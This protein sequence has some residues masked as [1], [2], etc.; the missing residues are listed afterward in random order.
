MVLREIQLEE[1]R[2]YLA[3][4]PK[5]WEVPLASTNMFWLSMKSTYFR[6][7]AQAIA[8]LLDNSIQAGA[9]KVSIDLIPAK[10]GKLVDKIIISDDGCGMEPRMMSEALSYGGTQRHNNRTGTGRFGMGMPNSTFTQADKVTIIS[11]TKDGKIH[12]LVFDGKL[13]EEGKYTSENG[14]LM[15]PEANPGTLPKD[16]EDIVTKSGNK[17]E[18]GTILILEGLS[19]MKIQR[20]AAL[21]EHLRQ[22]L[23]TIFN[24]QLAVPTGNKNDL[25]GK[26]SLFIEGKSVIPADPLFLT[27]GAQ[28]FDDDSSR[29]QPFQS[30]KIAIEQG[31][32]KGILRCEFALVEPTFWL[33][34]KK[35]SPV[36]SKNR[37]G[38]RF[39]IAKQYEGINIYRHDRLIDTVSNIP[40]YVWSNAPKGIKTKWLNN[41]RT[42]RVALYFE[43]VLDE[44][45]GV[46]VTKQQ[47]M[48]NEFIWN[49]LKENGF[50][51]TI[52]AM[53]SADAQARRSA[54]I[55]DDASEDGRRPSEVVMDNILKLNASD[56]SAAVKSF[57]NDEGEKCIRE[58]AEKN[59]EKLNLELTEENI[60]AQAEVIAKQVN[61]DRKFKVMYE[62]IPAAPFF[63]FG[64]LKGNF[65]IWLNKEHS[66]YS[67]LYA[68][69]S[70]SAYIRSALDIFL[71]TIA[72]RMSI[73]KDSQTLF[74]R[75]VRS[76]S[77]GLTD[78]L[79][80]LSADY[81]NI[82][83]IDE[84]QNSVN[85]K[86]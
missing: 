12:I 82:K 37:H 43:P 48:P 25:V 4:K 62:S 42:I 8:E 78:A 68:H 19:R 71:G 32:I 33:K 11:K 50:F 84:N 1:Q 26:L 10:D 86:S 35:A 18:Q 81:S 40:K 65:T 60:N 13:L 20:K 77:D 45:F 73:A 46:E 23:G 66:F 80:S 38:A 31:N 55:S 9:E 74:N 7:S 22:H 36:S 39:E 30:I 2:A 6:S 63:R 29:P 16:V 52:S 57:K 3:S 49:T 51:A 27:P 85:S 59:V 24:K 54:M 61:P 47:A 41:D 72:E 53:A 67:K 15:V 75:E 69:H 64:Y 5:G 28:G 70:S 34:D 17:F 79:D 14:T 56:E 76:W 83:E 44:F 21:V 58:E